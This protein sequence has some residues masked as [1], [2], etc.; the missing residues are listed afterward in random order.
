MIKKILFLCWACLTAS[1]SYAQSPEGYHPIAKEGKVWH[2]LSRLSNNE[3]FP[4]SY[5]VCGDTL[6]NDIRYKKVYYCQSDFCTYAAALRDDASR[7]Y[8][9]RCGEEKERLFYAHDLDDIGTIYDPVADLEFKLYSHVSTI[10]PDGIPL[11]QT[12]FTCFS[13]THGGATQTFKWVEGVGEVDAASDWFIVHHP[14]FPPVLSELISCRESD[15]CI[16][17]RR[18]EINQAPFV[19]IPLRHEFKGEAGE[20]ISPDS[21]W[22]EYASNGHWAF[23][24]KKATSD[25]K[26]SYIAESGYST[27]DLSIRRFSGDI[28][29]NSSL[30]MKGVN[31]VTIE[32][33]YESYTATFLYPFDLYTSITSPSDKSVNCK[34]V[35]SKWSAL[36]GRCLPSLPT[37]K[38]IYIK[39]G[40]KVLIK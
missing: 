13:P 19:R 30:V 27:K 23:F 8:Y 35:N 22:F 10:E 20:F 1:V 29:F 9:I 33:E 2:F 12:I 38:G 34:S 21:V 37:Q 5:E 15:M 4:F 26:L 14:S 31:V 18:E 32:N 25:Y 11:K 7:T 39:D 16:F 6:I 3:V 40:R 28:F 24:A 17:H 36:S